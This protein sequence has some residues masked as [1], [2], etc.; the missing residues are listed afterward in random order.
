MA[1]TR[2]NGLVRIAL[3][4]ALF[5]AG[6]AMVIARPG[7]ALAHHTQA[8]TTGD[9][10]A[11]TT[12]GEYIGGNEDRKAVVD[13]TINGEHILQTFYFDNEAGHLGHQDYWLL[14]ERSGS[15]SLAASGSIVLYSRSG[16]GAYTVVDNSAGVSVDMQCATE[17]ATP[18]VAASSTATPTATDTPTSTSTPVDTP[19]PEPTNTVEPTSTTTPPTTE[20]P[21]ATSTSTPANT[22]TSTAVVE[23]TV[24]PLPTSTPDDV[25][26][27]FVSTVEALLP[28][29]R[30]EQPS[31]GDVPPRETASGLP[32]TGAYADRGWDAIVRGAL[33]IALAALGLTVMA[34]GLRRHV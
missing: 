4:V 17:T 16:S 33:G 14:Y 18:T 2:T 10:T 8:S 29:Q 25:P 5:G 31:M 15:G 12:K 13:V 3:G 9:C 11:W 19:T 26:P 28:P 27:T 32:N 30:P 6:A 21:A 7:I 23:G 20:T 24:T 22:P 1:P 34:T